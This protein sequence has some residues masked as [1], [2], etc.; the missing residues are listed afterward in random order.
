MLIVDL[1]STLLNTGAIN[2]TF[3]SKKQDSLRHKLKSS[4]SMYES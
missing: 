3:Q 2:E 4:A 1:S